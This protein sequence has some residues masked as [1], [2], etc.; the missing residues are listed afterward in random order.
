MAKTRTRLTEKFVKAM[1]APDK[2]N[3][4]AY[5]D[6]I[7]GFG[8]RATKAG[9]KSFVLNYVIHGRERR[10][11][12]GQHPAWS[13]V[14]A[15]DKASEL[16]RMVDNGGDP[17]GN[18]ED[19][20][21][22]ISVKDLWKEF[23]KRHLP[24]LAERSC[25]D[26]ISMFSSYI[27]PQM[28]NIRLKDLT[29]ADIDDLHKHVTEHGGSTRAN[30][31][32]EMLRS[33]INKGIRWGLCDK[34]PA[35]GF[36][37]NAE[38]AKETYLTIEQLGIVFEKLNLMPNTKA[39]NIIR[40]LILTGARI[41]EVLNAEW[42]HFDMDKA[43]W[44]KPSSH[45]KQRRKHIVPIS[46]E[47]IELLKIVKSNNNS[48][49]LFPSEKGKPMHDIKKP[50][51]WLKK[52]ANMDEVRIHDLRHTF[53]SILINEGENLAIIGKLLGHTQHQ[54]TMRYAHILDDPLRMATGKI[55]SMVKGVQ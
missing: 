20:R 11:T 43:L 13:V 39:A 34:N 32:L 51:L 41:G 21:A 8:I 26:I 4:I 22:A 24:N 25:R 55:G 1:P 52:E 31:V 40:M 23:E 45:T 50:W 6:L 36:K 7:R 46:S 12:I 35:D 33:S 48:K 18:R 17:L 5:D 49:Y 28:G 27:I 9:S 53:A 44:I 15:R 38:E 19:E 16:K 42:I 10:Y 2:G 30:R 54:T 47:V 3:V 14:A 37:R 29:G